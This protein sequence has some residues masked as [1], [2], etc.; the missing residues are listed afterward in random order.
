MKKTIL[1]ILLNVFIIYGK[2]TSSSLLQQSK[3]MIYSNTNNNTQT[4]SL[5]LMKDI[6]YKKI[7]KNLS[8]LTGAIMLMTGVVGVIFTIA[9]VEADKELIYFG[10]KVGK[11][12]KLHTCTVTISGGMI[13]SG[14]LRLA[15]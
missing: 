13:L 1:I 15:H 14:M 3:D 6:R 5:Q 11:W 8:R 4:D 7:D 2:D 12:T 9:D 10:R